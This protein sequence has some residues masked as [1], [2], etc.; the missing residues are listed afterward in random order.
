M[1]VPPTTA[2]RKPSKSSNS[3]L[4]GEPINLENPPSHYLNPPGSGTESDVSYAVE[5]TCTQMNIVCDFDITL[6]LKF[7][8]CTHA[9]MLLHTPTYVLCS[10]RLTVI[11]EDIQTSSSTT[12][13]RTLHH[14][15]NSD[16]RGSSIQT[17]WI[18]D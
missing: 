4:M 13:T 10:L 9:Y 7:M 18:V 17:L 12:Q 6:H 8:V 2:M 5:L 3:S 11:C 15:L 16:L 1:Q 14:Q